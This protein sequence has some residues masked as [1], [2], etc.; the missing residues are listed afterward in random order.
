MV[1]ADFGRFR[2]QPNI[3][4]EKAHRHVMDKKWPRNAIFVYSFGPLRGNL[5][6]CPSAL[7]GNISLSEGEVFHAQNLRAFHLVHRGA[8]YHASHSGCAI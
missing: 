8:S 3:P 7:V 2:L 5:T 6:V 4:Q 1:M